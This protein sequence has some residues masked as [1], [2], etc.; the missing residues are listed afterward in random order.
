MSLDINNLIPDF[1]D[2]DLGII[3]IALIA[4]VSMFKL[5]P[6]AAQQIVIP[7]IAGIAGFVTGQKG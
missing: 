3:A 5:D 2:K 4:I 6:Q 1:D 7:C